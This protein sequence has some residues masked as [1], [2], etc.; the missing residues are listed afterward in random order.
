MLH[1]TGGAARLFFVVGRLLAKVSRRRILRV[2]TVL[3]RFESFL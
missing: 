3:S 2:R 1:T